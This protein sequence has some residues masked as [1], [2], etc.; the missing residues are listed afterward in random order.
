MPGSTYPGGSFP[1]DYGGLVLP[2]GAIT[3]VGDLVAPA[4]ECSGT[5]STPETDIIV[6]PPAPE[7]VPSAGRFILAP[8]V[9]ITG[10]GALR[11]RAAMFD[12]TA[13]TASPR[14]QGSGHVMA[15]ASRIDGV[16]EQD[17]TI[18]RDDDELLWLEAVGAL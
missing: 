7:E 16:G 13:R 5:G 6:T 17:V 2:A 12:G 8:Q 14:V 9:R 18:V 1:G 3:G 15:P 11:C 10:V 4:A